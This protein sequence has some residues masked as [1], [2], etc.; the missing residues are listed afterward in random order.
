[1]SKNTQKKNETLRKIKSIMKEKPWATLND[2]GNELNLTKERIRQILKENDIEKTFTKKP[3]SE[4]MS[5]EKYAAVIE[6]LKDVP[7]EL[8]ETTAKDYELSNPQVV[9][10]R[11]LL[12]LK[13]PEAERINYEGELLKQYAIDN[14]LEHNP[15][16]LMVHQI[17]EHFGWSIM[18]LHRMQKK[19]NV[20]ITYASG[21]KINTQSSGPRN[22]NKTKNAKMIIKKAHTKNPTA[23][24]GE[25]AKE[26]GYPEIIVKRE[27][28]IIKLQSK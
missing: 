20:Y 17:A 3:L 8:I 21:G 27:L 23:S 2:I 25:I 28:A 11:R 13:G 6:H 24:I 15:K 12:A 14:Q 19:F 7:Y 5:A 4:Q 10:F 22:K 26:T 9:A 16:K 18:K 1:M